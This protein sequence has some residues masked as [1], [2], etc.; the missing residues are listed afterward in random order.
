MQGMQRAW[1]TAMGSAVGAR[2]LLSERHRAMLSSRLAGLDQRCLLYLHEATA[3]GSVR[4]AA[5]RLDASASVLSRRIARMEADLGMQLMERHGRGVRLTEAGA[6]VVAHFAESRERL[7]RLVADLDDVANLRRG[8]VSIAA[9]EGFL[10]DLVERSLPSFA[11]RHADVAFEVR[12]GGTDE[13]VRRILDDAAHVGLLY[14]VTSMV[15]LRSH[16]SAVHPM[17]V[18]AGADHPL[19]ALGRRLTIR[20]LDGHAVGLL[21]GN[22]GV[23]QAL[24]SA[25][26]AGEVRLRSRLTSSSTQ[27]LTA[28]ARAWGGVF[29][30]PAFAVARELGRGELVALSM[31]EP[32]LEGL[33]AHLVTKTGRRLPL[34]A[35]GLLR[36]LASTL[37]VVGR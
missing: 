19:I 28:F 29:L 20:D 6:L 27:A 2:R 24:A 8:T 18:I 21:P 15:G 25:E 34:A 23:R 13:L 7:D 9:G 30:S 26:H 5:E 31:D 12:T 37:A 14:N 16:A 1:G 33:Q 32:S 22:T 35:D 17:R 4:A 3:A 10:D 36:H 11:G